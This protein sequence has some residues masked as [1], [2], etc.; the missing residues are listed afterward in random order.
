MVSIIFHRTLQACASRGAAERR[1]DGATERRSDGATEPRSG[2]AYCDVPL[3]SSFVSG[4]T[5]RESL[6]VLPNRD[7]RFIG[8]P[9]GSLDLV[10][11]FGISG[12]RA[13]D[14]DA[15][16]GTSA[17]RPHG[18]DS[19]FA[20]REPWTAFGPPIWP[21]GSPFGLRVGSRPVFSRSLPPLPKPVRPL[22]P[23]ACPA[24]TPPQC[25][26]PL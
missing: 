6:Y 14:G 12:I 25:A 22:P 19:R 1:S 10:S 24:G 20:G 9:R 8:R 3:K 13:H 16:L 11:R 26:H 7:S 2:N 18:G 21:A 4:V 5:R 17:A 23:P 15:L